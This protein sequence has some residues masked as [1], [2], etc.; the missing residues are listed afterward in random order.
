MKWG[1]T[2]ALAMTELICLGTSWHLLFLVHERHGQRTVRHKSTVFSRVATQIVSMLIVEILGQTVFAEMELWKDPSNAIL[3]WDFSI[4]QAQHVVTRTVQCPLLACVPKPIHA[5]TMGL[6]ALQ[7]T[8]AEQLKM[9]AVTLRKLAVEPHQNV[10][11]ILSDHLQLHVLIQRTDKPQLVRA[12][13]GLASVH[14]IVV[15]TFNLYGFLIAMD[16]QMFAHKFVVRRKTILREHNRDL[17]KMVHL[18]QPITVPPVFVRPHQ[19]PTAGLLV[20]L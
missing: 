5:V 15:Q 4:Q 7:D 13:R 16:K 1:I 9:Q 6:S 8:S 18:A 17:Q 10:L 11:R 14:L 3:D 20:Q 12:T 19:I 2:L